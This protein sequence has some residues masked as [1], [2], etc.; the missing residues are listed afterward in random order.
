MSSKER[1][2]VPRGPKEDKLEFYTPR[3]S[4]IKRLTMTP[5]IEKQPLSVAESEIV[6]E[7][8]PSAEPT[9]SS[10]DLL[11]ILYL[12]ILIAFDITLVCDLIVNS[13]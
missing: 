7:T 6:P 5:D 9:F 11:Q 10:D 4:G 12:A 1:L 3:Y 8:E 13:H 2:Y